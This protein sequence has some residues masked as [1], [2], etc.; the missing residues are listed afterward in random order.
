MVQ[1][2]DAVVGHDH[3]DFIGTVRIHRDVVDINTV[4]QS[5]YRNIDGAVRGGVGTVQFVY[6]GAVIPAGRE[7]QSV[8]GVRCGYREG[9]YIRS[10][11]SGD[12]GKR[13]PSAAVYSGVYGVVAHQLIGQGIIHDGL[14]DGIDRE[15]VYE[16]L[17][18]CP[19]WLEVGVI[20]TARCV[21]IYIT[22]L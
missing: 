20:K 19:V 3:Q 9:R 12:V 6:L 17:S 8:R 16:Q 15:G 11:R 14:I 10:G 4:V 21:P 22:Q 2:N 13:R 5:G 1:S 7:I 18:A